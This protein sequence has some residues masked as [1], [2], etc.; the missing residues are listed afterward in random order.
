MSESA[1][2]PPPSTP[3]T[4]G[5]LTR[6]DVIRMLA[7]VGTASA[8]GAGAWGVLEL[9]VAPG[10]GLEWHKSVCRFCGTGCGVMVG[11]KDRRIVD[12]R[13]DE[14]AHNRGMTCVKGS[15]LRVL[16]T[17][18]G[19]LTHPKIRRDDGKLADATWDE[20]MGLVARKVQDTIA[21]GGPDAVAFYGSGQLYIEESYTANKLFKAGIRTNNVD[22]NARLCMASA[23]FG[24]TQTFGKDEP[25]GAYEDI[26]HADCFFLIGA[27]PFEC[28]PP[29]FE[30]IQ[31]RRRLHPDTFVICVDPRRTQT[32]DRSD[33][34]LAP[35]PGTD[36]L[37]LNAMAQ[38][39][40][41]DRLAD[42]KFIGAHVRFSDGQATVGRESF[43]KF[44]ADYTPEKVEDRLG[45]DAATIRT[46]AYRFARSGATMS[47][48]TMGLNQRTQGTFVNN[49]VNGLHLLAGQIGRPGATPFSLTG[50]CNA[51]GG[52]RDTG[53]LAHLLPNGRVVANPKHR[54][55]VEA[56]W[57][58]PPGTISPNPGLDAVNLFRA[59]EARKVQAAL[60]MCTN[61]AQSLP[62]AVRYK[63]AM[64]ECFL[65]V[66]EIFED[67]ETADL[68]D[69]LLPAALWVEKEGVLG[70]GERRYQLVTKLLDPPG[71]A[72]SDL[73]I[74]VDLAD[75]LGHG[76]LIKARTSAAVW[77]EY[78]KFSASSFY[79]FAGMTRERLT[80]ERGLQWPC[81]DEKSPG[82]VRRYVEGSDPFVPKGAGIAF[83]GQPDKR[84]VVFQR[85]YVP[86]PEQVS[87]EFPLILTT[88]RVLEQW[89]TGTMTGRIDELARGS[90]PA[91]FEIHPSDAWPRGI[92]S[93]DTVEVKSRYGAVTGRATLSEVS[94]PGVL[95][96]SF[97]DSK[98]LVNDIVADNLD[99]TSKQPEFKVTAVAIRK[100]GAA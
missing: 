53:A 27:N 14:L 22:S 64:K 47:L 2:D 85:P 23:S 58:V 4:E 60:V 39:I 13:G 55:E 61:P 87:A 30:R 82:T 66:A 75:R 20:A 73:Q 48:W 12:V 99:A 54:A 84:A 94:R 10:A 5:E 95:F 50:Q 6:R 72:R 26:D 7:G 67:T 77:D 9:G 88:G 32:A 25:P 79:N 83:Y 57:G 28:H 8:L 45:I 59:M 51:C 98:L 91:R 80:Q 70:Q 16:N 52:V 90:G 100:L 65:A 15:M 86:S 3:L 24:Y 96:A 21:A 37:L 69:V 19:R 89:H 43:E 29:I 56:L 74:L 62:D 34:H 33:L 1:N 49:M 44:L 40:L 35:V 92:A 81:P 68:A 46:V 41:A 63:K 42:E 31:R 11:M 78:R 76:A 36:L 71:E 93:G 97:Y 18:P 38:V 17:I